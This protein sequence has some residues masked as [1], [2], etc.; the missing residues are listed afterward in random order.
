[1]T[2]IAR[3]GQDVF[4]EQAL[5]GFRREQPVLKLVVS[6]SNHLPKDSERRVGSGQA[7]LS[8]GGAARGEAAGRQAMRIPLPVLPAGSVPVLP[9]GSVKRV[10]KPKYSAF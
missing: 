2:F 9:A 4:G 7:N 5:A 8:Q 10:K 1:M 3:V 6:L